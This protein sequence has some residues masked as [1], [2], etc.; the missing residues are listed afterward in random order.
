MKMKYIYILV[1][2]AILSIQS[3]FAQ[4]TMFGKSGTVSYDKTMYIKN[5]VRK[6]YLEKSDEKSKG[7]FEGLIPRLPEN[8]ILKKEL[9]FTGDETLFAPVKQEMDATVKQ[10]IMQLALDFDAVTLSNFKTKEYSRFNDIIGQKIIIQDTVKTVKWRITDEYREIAGYNCRRAN[11]LTSD[12]V[13]V[14]GYYANEIPING[15]PESIN[16]LPGLI[17]GLVVPSQHVS[18]FATKVEIAD[19]IVLDKKPFEN[20]KTKRM[21]RAD[22]AKQF[23]ETLSNW[24]NKETVSYIMKLSLL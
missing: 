24:M 3:S 10:T 4:F 18:F 7:M 12:S 17:L 8:A 1:A 15:G 14:I 20:Q 22:M 11:G 19:Q 6:Q 2:L 5:I 9:K 16:G 23:T 21:T 13:Y